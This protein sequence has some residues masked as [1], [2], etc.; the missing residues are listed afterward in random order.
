MPI[1]PH[2]NKTETQQKNDALLKKYLRTLL[3]RKETRLPISII[4]TVPDLKNNQQH[5]EKELRHYLQELLNREDTALPVIVINPESQNSRSLNNKNTLAHRLRILP[6]HKW[7]ILI[8]TILAPPAHAGFY[9]ESTSN[10]Q[11]I[12]AGAFANQ[13][14]NQ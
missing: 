11:G 12:Y 7:L 6:Q 13:S 8:L 14:T 3:Q 1:L 4:N 9:P 10:V 2:H 5:A